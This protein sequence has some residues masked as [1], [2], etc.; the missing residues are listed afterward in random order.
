MKDQEYLNTKEAVLLITKLLN[1]VDLR[2]FLSRIE[3]AEAAGPVIAPDLYRQAQGN[4]QK[5]GEIARALEAAKSRI[6]K[7][8]GG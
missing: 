4:L 2:G 8:A 3:Q 7:I 5:I 1:L 6:Q